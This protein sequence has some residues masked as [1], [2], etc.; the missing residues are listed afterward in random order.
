MPEVSG[1]NRLLVGTH[2]ERLVEER[3]ICSLASPTWRWAIGA[4]PRP[5]QRPRSLLLN[6]IG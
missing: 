1:S 2:E 5:L 3:T 4:P 6:P